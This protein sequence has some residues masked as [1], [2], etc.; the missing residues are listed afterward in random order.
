MRGVP[1]FPRSLPIRFQN[2]ADEL[3]DRAQLWLLS[4]LA[5]SFRAATRPSSQNTV[6]CLRYRQV[7]PIQINEIRLSWAGRSHQ[8][9]SLASPSD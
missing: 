9:A 1:L 7:G 6:A 3:S 2:A 5:V 4:S 8:L